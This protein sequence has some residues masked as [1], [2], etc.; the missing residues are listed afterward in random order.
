[1]MGFCSFYSSFPL[2]SRILLLVFLPSYF[3]DS[4]FSSFPLLLVLA[5]GLESRCV[6]AHVVVPGV[7]QELDSRG[8]VC[9]CL[10]LTHSLAN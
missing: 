6:K 1:M 9:A 3:L 4:S 5:S 7:P 2:I 8:Q 10:Q